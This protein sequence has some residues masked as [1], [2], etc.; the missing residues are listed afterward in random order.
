MLDRGSI[1]WENGRARLFVSQEVK[2]FFLHS[3]GGCLLLFLAIN[4][5][6]ITA[7][8]STWYTKPSQMSSL[9]RTRLPLSFNY[10]EARAGLLVL[11][12]NLTFAYAYSTRLFV[13]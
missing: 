5:D 1:V 3:R 7:P 10:S 8:A 13:F 4:D 11:V 2:L 6:H 12:T 9:I